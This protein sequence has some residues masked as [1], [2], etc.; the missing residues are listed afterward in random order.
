[1]LR[2][3]VE[4]ALR[5]ARDEDGH[6]FPD[7][8]DYCFANA[9]PTLLSLLGADIDRSLPTARP[10][11]T[12]RSLPDDV[13]A[14]V[15]TDVDHVVVLFLDG[16][17]WDA[18]KRDH[19]SVP[20]LSRLTER[21]TVTPLTSIYPSETAA[22]T[23]TFHTGLTPAEH[24]LLGWWQYLLGVDGVVQTLPFET[25]DGDPADEAFPGLAVSDLYAGESIYASAEREGVESYLSHPF[26]TEMAERGATERAT[27]GNVADLAVQ[28]RHELEDSGGADYCFGYVPTVDAAAH[29]EGTTSDRY[30]AQ[31]EVTAACFRRELV[32]RLDPA[33]AERT[34]FVLTADHGIVDTV[35]AEN[36]D[37]GPDAYPA[38]WEALARDGDGEPIPPVGSPRNLHLHLRDGTVDAVRERLES[39]LPCRTFTREEAVDRRLF[40]DGDPSDLFRQRCGDL[41]VV[42]RDRGLCWDEDERELVGMHGG[43]TPEEMLVPFAAARLD[44]LSG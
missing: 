29:A 31:L 5:D 21:G 8:A 25:L 15:D 6:L 34:L 14:G 37:V 19:D 11:P 41:V 17:G 28:L 16:Y 13:F 42:H 12:D 36:V 1:M 7:Y 3:D 32:E 43:L 24:G 4:R 39:R 30:R 26:P 33:V 2:T 10:T 18:W 9:N 27:Y 38:V 23:T 22:A 40:G 20:L 44:R 35:P